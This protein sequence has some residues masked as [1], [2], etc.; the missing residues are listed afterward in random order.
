MEAIG[1]NGQRLATF[2][3]LNANE[4]AQVAKHSDDGRPTV[5]SV[6]IDSA[7]FVRADQIRKLADE[8]HLQQLNRWQAY[9]QEL[10]KDP[11]LLA[12]Y[13]FQRDD[14]HP[15]VLRNVAANGDRSLDGRIENTRWAAGRMPGKQALHFNGPND[16]VRIR[17][18]QKVD[19]I[20]LTAW[21]CVASFSNNLGAILASNNWEKD[22][23]IHWQMTSNETMQ[24][25]VSGAGRFAVIC[26]STPIFANDRFSRWVHLAA[27]YDSRAARMRL[28]AD[29]KIV[30]DTDITDCVLPIGI[31]E[32][33]IGRWNC[34]H[35][36]GTKSER[37]F[38]GRIDELAIFTRSLTTHEIRRWFEAGAPPQD[39]R[40]AIGDAPQNSET[41]NE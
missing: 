35:Y 41:K 11:S 32:A 8:Q 38:C 20:T 34:N 15:T 12:Y 6:T 16:S 36:S 3:I 1:V 29:G 14:S 40:A 17:V 23:Q 27:E 31:G 24:L 10:R 22:G 19:S 7:V 33:S 21:V 25:A 26:D 18:P 37:G 39:R 4:S 30:G 5:S 2:R 9:S 28:Y 13:D